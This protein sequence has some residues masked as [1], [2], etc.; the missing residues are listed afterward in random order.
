MEKVLTDFIVRLKKERKYV[1]V[2]RNGLRLMGSLMEKDLSVLD[3]L[4]PWV[5]ESIL[6]SAPKT[7]PPRAP[8]DDN[9]E[10]VAARAAILAAQQVVMNMPSL[11]A[12]T[13]V[14]APLKP[15]TNT[16][17]KSVQFT[18]A[19]SEDDDDGDTLVIKTSEKKPLAFEN[20]LA[21]LGKAD[22]RAAR[23]YEERLAA[24]L[25]DPRTGRLREGAQ[26][27][28]VD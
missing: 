16:L 8:D 5:R 21:S 9:L 18:A 12:T 4:F 19:P 24:G 26:D 20:M 23:L 28:Y 3:E 13:P 10:R 11:P 7:E 1:T 6:A 17:G 27:I 22:D 25:I 15:S 14:A 2:L